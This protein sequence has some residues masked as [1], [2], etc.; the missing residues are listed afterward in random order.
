[1]GTPTEKELR[2]A[3]EGHRLA[4]RCVLYLTCGIVAGLIIALL[5]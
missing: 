3:E 5:K 4:G 2:E 1:M